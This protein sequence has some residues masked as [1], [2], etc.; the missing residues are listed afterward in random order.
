M[1]PSKAESAVECVAEE[2]YPVYLDGGVRRGTDVVKALALGAAAVLVGKPLFFSLAVGGEDGVHRMFDIME[3]ELR[4]AMA[5][6]GC[7][8]LAAVRNTPDL[9]CVRSNGRGDSG[10]TLRSAL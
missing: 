2:I 3:K 4:S 5:L 9:A 7:P 10:T 6:C 1:Q 8:T